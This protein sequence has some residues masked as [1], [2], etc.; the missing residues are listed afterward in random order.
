MIISYVLIRNNITTSLLCSSSAA[1]GTASQ[2][3]NYRE[4]L[5]LGDSYCVVEVHLPMILLT[6][7]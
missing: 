5:M 3:L 1:L 2:R 4:N 6:M 7:E